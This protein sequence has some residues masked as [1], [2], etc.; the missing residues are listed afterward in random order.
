MW[1]KT[2]MMPVFGVFESHCGFIMWTEINFIGSSVKLERLTYNFV[3]E[4]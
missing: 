2:I 3:L 1:E 4:F